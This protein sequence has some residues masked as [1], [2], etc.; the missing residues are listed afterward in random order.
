[1]HSTIEESLSYNFEIPQHAG[2]MKSLRRWFSEFPPSEM[3]RI[4]KR[5]TTMNGYQRSIVEGYMKYMS[6]FSAWY[7]DT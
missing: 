2:A 5:P 3:S 1:M 7:T 6:V 4:F